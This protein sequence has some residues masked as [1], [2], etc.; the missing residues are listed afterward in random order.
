MTLT[1]QWATLGAMLLSGISMGIIFDGYRVVSAELRFTRFW[2]ALF[3]VLY[4]IASALIVFRMLYASNDGEVRAYVFIGLAFGVLGYYWMFSRLTTKIT[5]WLIK[6][7]K[8]CIQLIIHIFQI[9]VIKPLLLIGSIVL[10]LLKLGSKFTFLLYKVM[11][12]LLRPI[13]IVILW[14]I[15]PLTKPLIRWLQP[16]WLK[17]NIHEKYTKRWDLIRQS[18]QTK[19]RR[20]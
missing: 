13:W 17:W 8:W 5:L 9:L 16:Y 1:L 15:S 14:L 18:I 3:D 10:S 6:S 2:I 4:W 20:K 11:L 12:Q 7:I 19:L